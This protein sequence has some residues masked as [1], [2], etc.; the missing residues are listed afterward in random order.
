MLEPY[1][2]P[3]GACG[4]IPVGQITSAEQ[5]Y[6]NCAPGAASYGFFLL[7]VGINI[8]QNT[9][10]VQAMNDNVLY[11]M[12]DAWY[13]DAVTN[14]DVAE[15]MIRYERGDK[16]ADADHRRAVYNVARG[17]N[18]WEISYVRYEQ[19]LFPP[20][21][22]ESWNN[23]FEIWITGVLH[24]EDWIASRNEYHRGFA[25]HVDRVSSEE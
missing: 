21:Q 5:S 6:L 1:T 19:G 14:P 10:A 7:F 2:T 16:L 4:T 23:S 17:L 13:A 11:E 15:L 9:A 3:A 12:T 18:I 20:E 22:W 25:T 24:E 8:K